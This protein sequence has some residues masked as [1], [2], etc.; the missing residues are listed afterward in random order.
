MLQRLAKAVGGSRVFRYSAGP[1][2]FLEPIMNNI[3]LVLPLLECLTV[4]VT[5]TVRQR[6]IRR[7]SPGLV[8]ALLVLGAGACDDKTWDACE[9]GACCGERC[10]LD[11]SHTT[12][13]ALPW[14]D[15]GV[16]ASVS[17]EHDADLP[18]QVASVLPPVARANVDVRALG[19]GQTLLRT[20]TTSGGLLDAGQVWFSRTELLGLDAPSPYL[21]SVDGGR[22]VH[23]DAPNVVTMHLV[24]TGER[25]RRGGLY[26]T[27]ATEL[28]YAATHELVERVPAV[29]AK[30]LRAAQDD[31]ARR[32]IGVDLTNDGVVDYDDA[33]T[34]DP[35]VHVDAL[36]VPTD[37][38]TVD[39][40]IGGKKTT[41]AEVLTEGDA[42]A[43]E[44]A[45]EAV[46]EFENDTNDAGTTILDASVGPAPTLVITVGSTKPPAT[47]EDV[48]SSA[49][50]LD[51]GLTTDEPST[52]VNGT[53]DVTS[54][55]PDAGVSENDA[56]NDAG[57][58]T[59]STSSSTSTSASTSTADA[60]T[61]PN[62]T[63]EPGTSEE[64][65]TSDP[66][67]SDVSSEDEQSEI[68]RELGLPPSPGT[69]GDATVEGRDENQNRVRDDVE[70]EI[71][72]R[73]WP[74]TTLITQLWSLARLDQRMLDNA[75]DAEVVAEAFSEK[76]VLLGCLER[77]LG[78]DLNRVLEVVGDVATLQR[79]TS[80]RFGAGRSVET[81][82]AGQVSALPTVLPLDEACATPVP[83]VDPEDGGAGQAACLNQRATVITFF[84][85]AF[86]Q[87]DKA[88]VEL[89]AVRRLLGAL[90]EDTQ[91]GAYKFRLAFTD[92]ET[93]WAAAADGTSLAQ[94]AVS[95]EQT[96][97]NVER[98]LSGD[99]AIPEELKQPLESVAASYGE[100]ELLR[101]EYAQ[102][103]ASGIA[104]QVTVGN[105]IVAVGHG[106]GVA[107]AEL[108]AAGVNDA[109][110]KDWYRVLGLGSSHTDVELSVSAN[111]RT[112][113]LLGDWMLEQVYSVL[114]DTQPN[115]DVQNQ[116]ATPDPDQHAFVHAYAN[117][118]EAGPA[119]MAALAEAL[120]TVPY[121]DALGSDGII[122][123]TLWW[124]VQRDL[125]LHAYEPSGTHVWYGDMSGDSGQLDVDAIA[126]I[127]TEHYTVPC[128]TVALGSYSFGVNYYS[129]NGA[130]TAL[131]TVT[132]GSLERS[133]EVVMPTARGIAGNNSPRMVARV[134]VEEGDVEGTYR[135]TI[136]S[137]LNEAE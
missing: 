103:L 90:G 55:T 1:N 93:F 40:M 116:D 16:D 38:L 24:A 101:P 84:N 134:V 95:G 102:R 115:A 112:L 34:Y 65:T 73:Y 26:L 14:V 85:D 89:M 33:L 135:F 31:A 36:L 47:T 45:I 114:S 80:Q 88:V 56:G 66:S 86:T 50:A 126:A 64:V 105:R 109:P 48:T 96:L 123:V 46:L 20:L 60:S 27:V 4:G 37:A 49:P 72:F 63:D 131:V 97:A 76:R 69:S 94:Y 9:A 25:I 124:G 51:A 111:S 3:R 43:I 39:I 125:D 53:T 92:S 32:F 35:R 5:R 130:E 110:T 121:P 52:S 21:V 23:P 108:T 117:G 11:A 83:E 28:V 79:N 106:M 67:T 91:A 100:S 74:D 2:P 13:P 136:E 133:F 104:A 15:G 17:G 107:Y 18:F 118:D 137:L 78:G 10:E 12:L 54:R 68:E 75:N 122:T 44:R 132:A 7:G 58:V 120:E 19:A 98:W 6:F 129:G 61:E 59:A 70:R 30:T 22:M 82:L 42:A 128:D 113:N 87:H 119:L 29:D 8:S 81:Q 99:G 62:E 77:Y 127:G 57:E 41:L 71:A